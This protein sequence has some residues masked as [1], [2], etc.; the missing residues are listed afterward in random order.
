[1]G[2]VVPCLIALP[3]PGKRAKQGIVGSTRLDFGGETRV[4]RAL[5]RSNSVGTF[6]PQATR[7]QMSV[8]E[9]A[10]VSDVTQSGYLVKLELF[11][12]FAAD[13][14]LPLDSGENIDMAMVDYLDQI[15]LDGADM[16]D[17]TR[18]YAAWCWRNPSFGRN[19]HI[20]LSRVSRALQGWK[21]LSPTTTRAPMPWIFAALI[22]TQMVHDGDLIGGLALITMFLCYLRP[23]E[24]MRLKEADL[25]RPTPQCS[26]WAVNLHP[27][28]RG[29]SSKLLLSDESLMLDSSDLLSLGSFL[30][31]LRTGGPDQPLFKVQYPNMK[32]SFEK[33]QEK[34]GLKNVKYVMYQ[35]RHGGPSHDR[36]HKLRSLVEV[37]QRGRWVG[38]SSLRRYEA[39]A[40]VQQEEGKETLQVQLLGAAAAKSLETL[41]HAAMQRHP[42]DVLPPS[43]ARR[44]SSSSPAVLVSLA[45]SL[46]MGSIARPG[47]SST[48]QKRTCLR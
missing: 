13:L 20:R 36:R 18:L 11:E 21:K 33:A 43:R 16:D 42:A 32:K 23:G 29:E 8:L 2:T 45:P 48:G 4:E 6:Q 41:F 35:A 34:C 9:Q 10:S 28:S 24:A 44:S 14:Q 5:K 26:Y 47:T 39:H 22:A 17:A 30:D 46:G 12:Q 3:A 38:D 15:F 37:K 7:G 19:G 40:R 1:M 27:S 31:R 25:L